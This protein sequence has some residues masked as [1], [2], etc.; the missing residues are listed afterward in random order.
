MYLIKSFYPKK[1]KNSYNSPTRNKHHLNEQK[2]G[3]DTYSSKDTGANKWMK[4]AQS[5]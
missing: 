3:R 1:I 5:L 2:M 4:N